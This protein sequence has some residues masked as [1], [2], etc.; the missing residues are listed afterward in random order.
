MSNVN[1]VVG[2]SGVGKSTVLEETILLA[3]KD[4][5]IINYGDK[6]LE[7]AKEKDIVHNRDEMKNID[8]DTYKDIQEKA[9]N[10]IFEEAEDKEVIVDTHAAIKSPF[11]YIPGLPK[12]TIENLEPSKIIIIDAKAQDIVKRAETDSKGRKRDT[13]SS[14]EDVEEYREVARE[15]AASGAVLTGAYLQII[16]NKEGKVKET[17]KA[18]LETLNA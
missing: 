4:Y 6:M 17:A 12:W 18:L 11:G 3:E 15:M 7:I 1:I 8:V 2:L 9:A 13:K 16:E 5:E 10:K 14:V